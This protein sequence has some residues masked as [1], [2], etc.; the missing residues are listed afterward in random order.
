[1]VSTRRRA[2]IVA[3][4]SLLGCAAIG[5]EPAVL[6]DLAFESGGG[7]A[8]IGSVRMP[9]WSAAFAQATDVVSLDNVTF[10]IGPD[11]FRASRIDVSG[12]T[13][14]RADLE[15]LFD[16]NSTEPLA[17]RLAR[18]SAKQ[19]II[20]ELAAERQAGDTR[21]LSVYRNVTL[22]DIAQGRIGKLTADS[23][24][25]EVKGPKQ[26]A[27]L[28]QGRTT[29]EDIDAAEAARVYME[30][31]GPQPE[32]LSRLY[33]AFSVENIK[34]QDKEG[35]VT[36]A[37]GSGRDVR[38]RRTED[39]WAGTASLVTA[40]GEMDKPSEQDSARLLASV[41][42]LL[43]AIEIGSAEL[44]GI[45]ASALAS[46]PGTTTRIARIGYTGTLNGQP[47]D[48]RLEGLDVTGNNTRARIDTI[49]FTGFSLQATWAELRTFKGKSLDELDAAAFRRM[50][51]TLGTVHVSGLD[52]D[53]PNQEAKNGGPDKI[54][55]KL[56][57][58]ELTADKPRNGIPTNV[59]VALQNFAA[60]IPSD[61][62]DETVKLFRDLGYKDLN[63]S[64]V[65]AASWNEAANE[66]VIRELS[67]NGQDMGAVT[68]HG[69]LGNVTGDVFNPDTALASV[70][71]IGAVAKSADLT[72][73]NQGIV[74]RYLAQEARKQK[75]SP[76]ALGREYGTAAA[77]AVPIMLGNSPQAKSLGQAVARFIAKP[78]RLIVNAKAKSP[79]GLGLAELLTTSEPA[80]LFSKLYV[81]AT[82]EDRP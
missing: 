58:L 69:V 54:R 25:I 19:A 49:S 67:Y 20:P 43:G 77:L 33:G 28:T 40:L 71:L 66:L 17:A 6:R 27:T 31:A 53:V 80:A 60:P 48:A 46:S 75:K 56:K 14:T 51:P 7:R 39:S 8:T 4:A 16:K 21:Q 37:H 22:S 42:D 34:I 47:A 12:L 79:T 57:D 70:A 15:A 11:T 26:N 50:V 5:F 61:T 74:D 18:V 78:G 3:T 55:F 38:G 24:S 32:P 10:S 2:A 65:T 13:S 82:A 63:V 64:F 62:K 68:L 44:T 23:S 81:T 76:E 45:E 1:M 9:L 29:A 72:I 35:T 30:K 36:I 73:D 52:F 41:A 59:R